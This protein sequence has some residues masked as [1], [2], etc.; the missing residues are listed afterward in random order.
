[1]YIYNKRIYND[2]HSYFRKYCAFIALWLYVFIL[3]P[4]LQPI[5]IQDK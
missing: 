5:V 4:H 2:I 3:F 1:M